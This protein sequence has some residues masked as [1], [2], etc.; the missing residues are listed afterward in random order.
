MDVEILVEGQAL[1][2][3]GL[4][5]VKLNIQ[6]S[7]IFSLSTVNAS[8]IDAVQAPKTARNT[9]IMRGLGLK[10]D[11]SRVPYRKIKAG[12]KYYGVDVIADAWL[13]VKETSDN[14]KISLLDGIIDFMKLLEGKKFGQEIPLPE[15]NHEKTPQV[16]ADSQ[17]NNL[18]SYLLAD[19]GGKTLTALDDI[20]ADF[21]TPSVKATYLLAKIQEFTGYTFTG[22]ILNDSDVLDLWLT[23]PKAPKETGSEVAT[24][25]FRG[26]EPQDYSKTVLSFQNRVTELGWVI[27][28]GTIPLGRNEIPTDSVFAT[29]VVTQ[30]QELAGQIYAAPTSGTYRFDLNLKGRVRAWVGSARYLN[31]YGSSFSVSAPVLGQSYYDGFDLEIY[32]NGT[33]VATQRSNADASDTEATLYR[34]LSEGD[35]VSFRYAVT[36]TREYARY[37][38]SHENT[39]VVLSYTDLGA[40]DFSEA[41]KEFAPKDF[42]KEFIQRYGITPITD[43]KNKTIYLQTFKEKLQRANAVDWSDKFIRRTAESYEVPTYGQSNRFAHKYNEEGA[44]YADGFIL[45]DNQNLNEQ[46]TVIASKTF[47]PSQGFTEFTLGAQV[48]ALPILPTWVTEVKDNAGTIEVSYK[49]LTNRFY[50][51]KAVTI[52]ESVTFGSELLASTASSSSVR[53]A[54]VNDT[55]FSALVPKYYGKHTDTLNDFK[56]HDIELRLSVFDLISLNLSKLFYFEQEAQFYI[57]NKLSFTNGKPSKGEFIRVKL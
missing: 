15:I 17:T 38:F 40:V 30:G 13:V 37:T 1:E 36:F 44:E 5:Q 27:T 39:E 33:L 25:Y 18:Y 57:L 41:L 23:Y 42:F 56:R 24:E 29:T 49:S 8:Y 4:E 9:E 2:L 50:F 45:L 43:N 14:Y 34:Y 19:Y 11:T 6:V 55:Q 26:E 35:Q 53:I 3:Q 20:N 54:S 12:L 16:V 52:N 7:D 48:R 22:A 21:L 51:V 10:G 28:E 47:A 31:G 32:V 46:V